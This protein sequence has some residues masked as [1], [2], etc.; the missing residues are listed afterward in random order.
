MVTNNPKHKRNSLLLLV[1]GVA[2]IILVNII[3][4]HVFER[5]DLTSEKRFSL[6]EATKTQ[7]QELED[8]V[9]IKVYLA[10]DLPADFKRLHD[11]TQEMIDEFRVYGAD[12]IQY[13]FID[14]S[15]SPDKQKRNNIYR[16]LSK[17]GLMYTNLKSRDGDKQ[18]EQIVFP[19]AILRY[20]NEEIPVQLLKSQVGAP[21]EVML[22]NSIQQLEYE[23][24]SAIQALTKPVAKR[25]FFITGHD[26]HSQLE[27]SDWVEGLSEFYQVERVAI[28]GK[29]DALNLADAIVIAG[30]DSAFTEKDKYII[31][32]F[33]MR[34]GKALWLVEPVAANMDSIQKNGIA[35]GLAK[36]VNL[37]DQLFKY[38]VRLNPDLV[39][40]LQAL[41]IPVVTGMIGNQPQQEFFPWYYSPLVMGNGNHP[42]VNNIDALKTDF[43]STIDF[44]RKEDLQLERTVLLTSSKYSKLVK[45]PTRISLNILR[46]A[47]SKQQ[48]TKGRLPVAVLLEGEFES[49]FKNRLTKAITENPEFSYKERS[50]ATK[51]IVVSDADIAA[52][53]VN[54]VK[55]E[56][57][58]LGF[59]KYTG[60]TYGNKEF[61]MNCM[62]Y[63]LDDDGL[64]N[65]RSK[66]FRIRLL[67]EQQVTVRA[68]HWQILNT[69]IPILVV[70]GFGLLHFY[71]RKIKY[72]R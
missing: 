20:R 44:V 38:G 52:N 71:L 35:M 69:A 54:L 11:A 19:G 70:L 9:T 57:Y 62:N 72:T 51:M 63:L 67:D 32:Q 60:R 47:P 37:G 21:R 13:E 36:D 41:P 5:F 15:A 24:S 22:N 56:Y 10:G 53:P 64:I 49:V 4:D 43:I 29:V 3:S 68:S 61:L 45:A 14:P 50:I 8:I 23:L 55:D 42:I 25:I 16:E 6:T 31:D 7:L 39:M 28:E 2:A 30:P 33:I 12:N 59:D 18:T 58:A 27:T 34:G 17:K 66:V 40:D 26:E 46:E 65:A 48:Y 1:Y